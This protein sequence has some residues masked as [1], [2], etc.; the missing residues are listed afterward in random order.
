MFILQNLKFCQ[1]RKSMDDIHTTIVCPLF[2]QLSSFSLYSHNTT[3]SLKYLV[4]QDLDSLLYQKYIFTTI[5]SR[6]QKLSLLFLWSLLFLT[7]L[8]IDIDSDINA[9]QAAYICQKNYVVIQV[10]I[11]SPENDIHISFCKGQ[12]VSKT[13]TE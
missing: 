10:F 13:W 2:D 7:L 12:F 6:T 5:Q 9:Y 4:F 1:I 8:F 11:H 3:I